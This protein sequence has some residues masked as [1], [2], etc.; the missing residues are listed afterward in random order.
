MTHAPSGQP[1]NLGFGPQ[2]L[3]ALA[4]NWWMFLL[5]GIAAIVFGVLAFVWPGVTLL[6]LVF[7]YG[8]FAL[9]DGV[10]AVGAAVMGGKGMGP[11]W[12]LA[13][14]GLLG[15]GAGLLTFAWPGITALV[16][17]IFIAAWSI[18][19]GVFQI[20]GAIQLRKEID[21]EWFLILSGALSLLFGIFLLAQPGTGALA[22]IWVIGGYAIVVGIVYVAL[23]FKLKTHKPA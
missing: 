20:F 1:G 5:R 13:L 14:I 22:L 19:I 2:I 15:I 10:C 16:L 7:L 21:N 3:H 9:V 11:R 23:A 17:L 6:T 4:E 12:W 8:A 18:L